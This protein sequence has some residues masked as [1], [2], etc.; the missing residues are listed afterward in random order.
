MSSGILKD[1]R[2]AGIVSAVPPRVLTLEDD[3]QIFGQ[4]EI[5]R[6]SQNIGVERRHVVS[7]T[8]CTSDLCFAAANRLL[9]ELAWDRGTVDALVFVTQTPDYF[10]PA[11]ACVLQDR[12][13]LPHSCAAFDVNQ[14]CAGYVYG[15]WIAGLMARGGCRRLLLLVGDTMSRLVSPRDRTVTSLFGDAG[16]ATAL[17]YEEGAP[18]MHFNLGT[19]GSGR[20]CLSVAAGAFRHPHSPETCE[21][22]ER[23][24]G[25]LRSDEDLFMDGA[26]VFT[27]ALREVPGLIESTLS[28][29]EA[30]ADD[31]HAFVFHQ[32]NRFMLGHLTKRLKLPTERVAIGLRNYGNTSSASIPLA[33]TTELRNSLAAHS[34]RLLLAGFG[35]GFSWG[36]AVLECG[37]ACLPPVVVL[38]E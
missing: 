4:S 10:M 35:A 23:A 14:G 19:D 26:E 22:I 20:N 18:A 28:A 33:I 15:L 30:R 2:I 34:G 11:T 13:G 8:T 31:I 9:D 6:I 7:G 38:S 25:N 27:F 16:T 36:A 37:P 21:R 17:E 24:G 3:A 12:L 32:A 1:V 5:E 29:A